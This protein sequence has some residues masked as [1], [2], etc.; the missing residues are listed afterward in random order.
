[1]VNHSSRKAS[2]TSAIRSGCS[3]KLSGGGVQHWVICGGYDGQISMSAVK[4]VSNRGSFAP[5]PL[6]R[7]H[8]AP[9]NDR[10]GLK[11]PDFQNVGGTVDRIL[12]PQPIHP[13]S[14]F[15]ISFIHKLASRSRSQQ[16]LRLRTDHVYR[17]MCI[18]AHAHRLDAAVSGQKISL[19]KCWEPNAPFCVSL[20]VVRSVVRRKLRRAS[21]S[22]P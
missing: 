14:R 1:M 12:V 5:R 6:T 19:A 18:D 4:P 11:R 16:A 3:G 8:K 15:W 13:T 22:F 17:E 9:T 7:S 10:A 2:R 20:V 21:G